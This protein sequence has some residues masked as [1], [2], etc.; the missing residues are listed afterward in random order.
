MHI[1]YVPRS[2]LNAL[3]VLIN[4]FIIAKLL[5]SSFTDK[6]TGVKKL[7][8]LSTVIHMESRQ[9]NL[10][11]GRRLLKLLLLITVVRNVWLQNLRE[12]RSVILWSMSHSRQTKVTKWTDWNKKVKKTMKCWVSQ[13]YLDFKEPCRCNLMLS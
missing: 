4:L 5:L 12:R 3:H 1:Y 6:E 8:N 11:S 9:A 10:N 13:F 7:I 2:I